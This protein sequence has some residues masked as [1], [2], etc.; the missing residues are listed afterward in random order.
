M[1]DLARRSTL[2]LP[3]VPV[4]DRLLAALDDGLPACAGVAV[5]I[6][7]LLMLKL[8]LDNIDQVLAFPVERA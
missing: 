1:A 7:R 6:D 2:G 3:A 4:D 5:G 8:G